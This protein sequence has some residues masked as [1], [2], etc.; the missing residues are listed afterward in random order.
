MDERSEMRRQRD[1]L[2]ARKRVRISQEEWNQFFRAE[3][4]ERVWRVLE[5]VLWMMAGGAL[6]W[7]GRL[8]AEPSVTVAVAEIEAL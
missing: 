7:L 4:L 1:A 3:R 6:T 2:Y 5:R 8:L